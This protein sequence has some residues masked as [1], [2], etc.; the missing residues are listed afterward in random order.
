M[1]RRFL[2]SVLAIFIAPLSALLWPLPPRRIATVTIIWL[3]GVG[4]FF[5]LMVGPG[6]AGML[7]AA[8]LMLYWSRS[9]PDA[10]S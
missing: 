3:L 4:V 5:W 2:L 6:L 1:M 8:F 7:L 10:P 9:K